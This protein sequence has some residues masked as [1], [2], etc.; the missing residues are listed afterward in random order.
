MTELEEQQRAEI[1]K[2]REAINKACVD[3]DTVHE[4]ICEGRSTIRD[5]E[6]IIDELEEAI[7]TVVGGTTYFDN[8]GNMVTAPTEF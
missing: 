1:K 2:L 3:F 8:D 7:F 6:A 5:V 4:E